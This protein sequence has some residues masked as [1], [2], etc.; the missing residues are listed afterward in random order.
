[1]FNQLDQIFQK[2]NTDKSSL[3]HDYSVPYSMFFSAFRAN[4][5]SLLEI[6]VLNGASLKSWYDFFENATIIG[7]DVDKGC[8]GYSNDRIIIE[9]GNQT[10]IEFLEKI[11]NKYGGFDI[12]IDDGGH[13]W[14][15]QKTTFQFLFRKLKPDGIY[16]IED[17]STSYLTGQVWDTGGQNTVDFLKNIIDDLNLN[18][19]SIC[20]VKEVKDQILNYYESWVEYMFFSKGFALVKKRKNAVGKHSP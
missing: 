20:G 18:G 14:H 16:V 7:I 10:D 19:K 12:I 1:M 4:K 2:Y 11:D 3:F 13:T 17:L 5:L 9:I 15:Q 8:C 6:G